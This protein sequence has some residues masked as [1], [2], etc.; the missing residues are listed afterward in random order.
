MP[1]LFAERAEAQTRILLAT[2][3][4]PYV[5]NV[6]AEAR[7]VLGP[8]FRPPTIDLSTSKFRGHFES[9]ATN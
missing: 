7:W 9:W 8:G 5:D 1:A 2:I 3:S 6:E 4:F